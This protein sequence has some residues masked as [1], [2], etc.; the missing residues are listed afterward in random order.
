MFSLKIRLRYS[1][2]LFFWQSVLSGQQICL[3]RIGFSGVLGG[4]DENTKLTL[5]F[6]SAGREWFPCVGWLSAQ[7][8]LNGSDKQ[9]QCSALCSNLL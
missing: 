9:L 5:V 8:E 1:V 3:P 4:G 2:Y 6:V 7:E